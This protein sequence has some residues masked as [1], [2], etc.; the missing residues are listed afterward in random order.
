MKHPL[1]QY[2]QSTFSAWSCSDNPLTFLIPGFGDPV[3]S[4]C[5]AEVDRRTHYNYIGD[6]PLSALN[7]YSLS[8]SFSLGTYNLLNAAS[9]RESAE[10]MTTPLADAIKLEHFWMILNGSFPNDLPYL[11]R[12]LPFLLETKAEYTT[13][14]VIEANKPVGLVNVGVSGR[15]ALV[16]TASILPNF[17]GRGLCHD[18]VGIAKNIARENGAETAMYW[19][20]HPFLLRYADQIYAYQ[21]FRRTQAT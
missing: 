17:R 14:F 5:F 6:H 1:V 18:L 20:E 4:A 13:A 15:N 8:K 10:A 7:G 11:R 16:L 21:I 9:E 3:M 2:W 19:T 12:L